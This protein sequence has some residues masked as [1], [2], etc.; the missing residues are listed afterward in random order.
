ML[1]NFRRLFSTVFSTADICDAVGSKAQVLD[2]I[3]KSYG[4]KKTFS[5]LIKTIRCF[6]NN[7]RLESILR[8]DGS[9][10]VLIVDNAGSM[11]CAL[12]G[13]RLGKKAELNK[14]EGI[15]I[16]GSV[17]DVENLKDI[18]IGILALSSN[19]KPPDRSRDTGDVN[20]PLRF[21]G[22]E[23]SLGKFIYVDPDGVVVL[24]EEFSN[25]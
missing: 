17:R 7:I 23:Y 5:G 21:A 4:K 1:R 11:R 16:F 18:N 12:V 15:V 22:G 19:P 10:Q 13:D 25:N 8:E 6:D 20:V 14:W 2:P 3:F 24:Q 9:G